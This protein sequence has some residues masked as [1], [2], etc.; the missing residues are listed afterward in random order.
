[1]GVAS[2]LG[3]QLT[4]Y[5][6][7]IRTFIPDYE[8]MLDAAANV[9]A[10]EARTIVELG[11]GTGA[12]AARCL[13]QAP[14]AA[15]V[16]FD[17]DPGILALAAR[18]LRHAGTLHTANFVRAALPRADAVVA[19]FALH[20]VRTRQA[21][22]QLYRRIRT[23]LRPG[24]LLIS[25]DCHPAADRARWMA[26][27]H[28]WKSH[29]RDS[30]GPAKAEAFLRA[31]AHEDVYVP[32]DAELLLLRQAGFSVDVAWRR[33]AFAVV[34][35]APP[36]PRRRRVRNADRKGGARRRRRRES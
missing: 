32:L 30:Y 13:K 18:R 24:G 5:D 6:R 14:A 11:I 27:R 23:A 12:L 22:T 16:G 36:E 21:K 20:H 9:V 17:A 29:L 26:Q 33:E 8:E 28:A 31:W 15:V 7:R 34:G 10:P 2:H 3:I 1:V 19:S 25:A 4:E 35:L